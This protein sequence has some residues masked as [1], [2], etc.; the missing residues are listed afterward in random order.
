MPKKRTF[1]YSK[2]TS[3]PHPSLASSSK[4]DS[5][6]HSMS[7]SD[8]T[9]TSVNELIRHLR[10]TQIAPA[11]AQRSQL[12]EDPNAHTVHPSLKAIL[13]LPDTPA[14]R[15]RPGMRNSEGRRARGP[16]GPPPPK[17][18]LKRRSEGAA[19]N[20]RTSGP[21]HRVTDKHVGSL[22]GVYFPDERS[23][24]H[25]VLKSLA[26]NWQWHT[27]YDQFHLASLPV[28]HKETLLTYISAY[29][30]RGIDA[31]GIDLLFLDQSELDG[32]TGSEGLTHLDIGTSVGRAITLKEIKEALTKR[33]MDGINS[34]GVEDVPES[35]DE[36]M[37]LI[38]SLS[39]SRFPTL[40]HLSLS[41][42]ANVSWKGL[43]SLSQHLA[44]L[45]HLALAFWPIPSVTPNSKTAY[46]ESPAGNIDYGASNFYSTADDDFSEAAGVL[47]RLSKATYCLQWLDLTGCCEWLHV[48]R[49][50]DGPDWGGAWRGLETVKVGQGWIPTCLETPD[51]EWRQIYDVNIDPWIDPSLLFTA[52][53]NEI[54][55]WAGEE[56]RISKT[57]NKAN[58][59]IRSARISQT[60]E[61][62]GSG[63]K[64]KVTFDR[65]WEGWWIEDALDHISRTTLISLP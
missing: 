24:E 17:S 46:R 47:K 11:E 52:P 57:V 65:G 14:P 4:L 13:D 55:T 31:A 61:K 56:N 38:A 2:P 39:M 44:T 63:Q 40:T 54:M 20:A 62:V 23:L 12:Q 25:L 18:W 16:A 26:K 33:T 32:A 9:T 27:R 6:K 48:L 60:S 42:P 53:K 3:G 5:S 49:E 10:Q 45:T 15:P 58:S 19:H 37:P 30:N 29:N 43:L 64:E 7:G 21:D 59:I 41:N 22:P 50:H 8:A 35:W 51:S 1:Q 28:R 36:D 34:S